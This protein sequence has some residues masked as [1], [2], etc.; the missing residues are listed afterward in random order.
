MNL[1][2]FTALVSVL[3]AIA[4]ARAEGTATKAADALFQAG[5]F[6]EADRAYRAASR[7]DPKNTHSILRLGELALFS[8]RLSEAESR[9]QEVL[10]QE[11][12][13]KQA[14]KLLAEAFYR[15][16]DFDLF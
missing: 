5:R 4:G 3:T 12:D 8:N 2:T 15:Q 11:A 13:N 7:Q 9:L 6:A 16:V 10:A 14:K 1:R